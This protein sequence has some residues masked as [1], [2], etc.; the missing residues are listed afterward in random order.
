MN[1]MLNTLMIQHTIYYSY[2]KIEENPQRSNWVQAKENERDLRQQNNNKTKP[3]NKGKS[4]LAV[5]EKE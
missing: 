2:T 3:P 1:R 5:K 4:P